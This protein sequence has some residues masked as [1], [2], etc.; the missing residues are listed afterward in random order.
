LSQQ[1]SFSECKYFLFHSIGADHPDSNN[2]FG[3]S[4]TVAAV[5]SLVFNGR[6]PP[7]INKIDIISLGKIKPT[8]PAFKLIKIPGFLYFPEN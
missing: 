8:P 4:Y 1:F 5:N 7:W 2:I 6:I 3:L